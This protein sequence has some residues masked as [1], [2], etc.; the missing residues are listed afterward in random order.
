MAKVMVVGSGGREHAL[1][2]ALAR[3]TDVSEVFCAPGNPGMVGSATLVTAESP[4]AI[5]R[6][7][8]ELSIDLVVVG[9]EQPLVEGLADRLRSAGL[10]VFGP[11]AVAAQIEGDKH[12]AKQLLRDAGVPVAAG[13]SFT[14]LDAALSYVRSLDGPC[15]VKA[16]GLAAG[17]GV[18]VCDDVDQA[19][20]AVRACLGD[21]AFGEAGSTVLVEERLTGPELSVFAVADGQRLAWFAPGR[22]HKRLGANDTGPN[23]GGMGAYTPV[24]DATP[25]LMEQVRREILE[26]TLGALRARGLDYRGLLYAGLMLTPDGPKVLE[27]NCRFGDPETQV[28]LPAFDGDLFAVLHGAAIGRLPIEGPLSSEGAAAGVVLASAGY[29][30]GAQKGVEIPGL[31]RLHDDDLVF[32]AATRYEGGRWFTNGGRVLCAVGRARTLTEARARAQELAARL[33]FEGAQSRADIALQEE[34]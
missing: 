14:E 25:E 8:R 29:P 27:Y 6:A 7:A 10:T 34:R 26:P 24:G 4:A 9:P 11:G 23:T 31:S 20:G 28:V 16:S 17:K 33:H 32:H 1:V 2:H 5:E 19:L 21:R 18:T 15:V 30:A 3:A 13:E 22:D 12:W